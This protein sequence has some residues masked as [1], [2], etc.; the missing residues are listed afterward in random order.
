MTEDTFQASGIFPVDID[1]FNSNVILRA[2]FAAVDFNI[3]AEIPSR[4]L[5][6]FVSRDSNI[7]KHS[8]SEHSNS[9]GH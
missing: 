8:S 6:F 9:S 5:A 2:V 3:L 7:S 4:P 1:L